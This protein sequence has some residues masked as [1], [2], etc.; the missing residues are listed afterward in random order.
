MARDISRASSGDTSSSPR[1]TSTAE[2][3][4]C[5]R[6]TLEQIAAAERA[7]RSSP[8]IAIDCQALDRLAAER[9]EVLEQL[10]AENLRCRREVEQAASDSGRFQCEALDEELRQQR[11]VLERIAAEALHGPNRG[12]AG[13]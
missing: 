3:L 8:G 11:E 5:R 2:S 9:R 6:E 13:V 7:R 4:R 12:R 10:A 1:I